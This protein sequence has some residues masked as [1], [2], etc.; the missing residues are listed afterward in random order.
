MGSNFLSHTFKN[1]ETNKS[2][3]LTVIGKPIV[4][5]YFYSFPHS[6]GFFYTVFYMLM[7]CFHIVLQ[8]N[9]ASAIGEVSSVDFFFSFS[10]QSTI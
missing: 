1:N 2:I 4:T 7:V 6:S 8:L 5:Q 9:F 10:C 3:A